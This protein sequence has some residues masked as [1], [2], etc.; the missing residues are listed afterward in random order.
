MTHNEKRLTELN[1]ARRHQ[2]YRDTRGNLTIGV[3]HNLENGLTDRM[4][5]FILEEDYST[6]EQAALAAFPWLAAVDPVRKAAVVDLVFN[7]GVVGV[8]KFRNTLLSLERGKWYAAG[9]G[10]RASLWWKQVGLRGPRI[11]RM[12]EEGVWPWE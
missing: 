2:Y 12:I 11:V 10:L 9:Q 7:M 8:K 3:G 6:A 5:D 4:I 1:E